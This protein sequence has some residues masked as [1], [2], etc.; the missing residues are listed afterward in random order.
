MGTALI[1]AGV[2]LIVAAFA[3]A[4][5]TTVTAGNGGGPMTSRLSRSTW[6]VLRR[7]SGTRTS[8]LLPYAGSIVLLLTVGAWVLLLWAGWS[9]VFLG[10][11]SAIV[12]ASTGAPA[13]TATTIYYAGFV[14][15]TLGVGDV[16]AVTGAWQVTTALASLVGLS[17]VTL[18]I[19]YLL[20]VVSAAVARRRL[21]QSVSIL[22]TSGPGIVLTHW[23]G[24][25]LSSHLPSRVQTLTS[26]LLTTTQQHLAYPVLHYFHAADPAASA[27]RAVAA[28]DDALVLLE[29]GVD[30]SVAPAGDLLLPLRRAIE[31]YTA[32]VHQTG[33]GSSGP[34][35][36]PPLPSL[37]PLA[38]AGVPVVDETTYRARAAGHGAR[39]AALHRIVR[40]DARSWPADASRD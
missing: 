11:D 5:L 30:P 33:D 14:V 35:P 38:R 4:A 1:A 40:S 9:L 28:L 12:Q 27:P 34:A 21:A 8:G 31:S 10:A 16:V 29:S 19:T 7:L 20:S 3:D 23:V 6:R 32:I 26:L 22:G 17:L 15:S 24:G 2:A 39:R 37:D 13:S 18:S 36:V 25:G